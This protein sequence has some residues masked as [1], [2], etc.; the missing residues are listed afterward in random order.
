MTI[1]DRARELAADIWPNAVW[2]IDR[3]QLTDMLAAEFAAVAAAE[4]GRVAEELDRQSARY[5]TTAGSIWR[6][7]ADA[8]KFVCSLGDPPA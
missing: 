7:W 8:A 2:D 4:R 3:D 6:I 1:R 5:L